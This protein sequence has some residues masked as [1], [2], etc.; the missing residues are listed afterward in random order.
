MAATTTDFTNVIDDEQDLNDA[1][2]ISAR[3]IQA[4]G[5]IFQAKIAAGTEPDDV[6]HGLYLA[7]SG[8]TT[9][10]KDWRFLVDSSGNFDLDENTGTDASPTWTN[11]LTVTAGSSFSPTP[12]AHASSHQHGGADEVATAT[13]GANAIVKANGSGVLADG[14]LQSSNV[15]QFEAALEG[16]LDHDDLQGFVA[17][18]HIDWSATGA[19][20]IHADRLTNAGGGD[21]RNFIINSDFR[22]GQRGTSFTSATTPAN[23]DDTYLLDR[24]TLLSDGNDIVDVT[25]QTSDL[26]I[27][28]SAKIRLDVETANAKFG[29]LQVL[30]S[31]DTRPFWGDVA[32]LSFACR[33]VGGTT[34]GSVR[35]MILSWTSTA[36]SVTSDVVSAWNAAG[37][38]P[39]MVANWAITGSGTFTPTTSWQTFE[40]EN[41]S[42]ASTANNIA[43]LIVTDDV[44]TTVGEFLEISAVQLE[45]S[46]TASAYQTPDHGTDLNACRLFYQR[47]DMLASTSA[48]TSITNSV[49]SGPMRGNPTVSLVSVAAG[50]GAAYSILSGGADKAQ[51][52]YQSTANDTLSSAVVA[53]NSEL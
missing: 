48:W 28:S 53:L 33:V 24:W 12:A 37:A 20:Q 29:L 9:T 13:P 31:T 41:V 17:A 4:L 14:W 25:R 26:P 32:S 38:A 51:L 39:T 43:V 36:D 21:V 44:T 45:Q 6:L 30:L 11:R 49:L 15:T 7:T 50:T 35:A 19:E 18:E 22:V 23:S 10:R 8:Q 47:F 42:I 16:V 40:V 46:A 3:C 34:I 27:G 5:A 2:P 1:W 52:V